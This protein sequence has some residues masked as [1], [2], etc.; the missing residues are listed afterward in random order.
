MMIYTPQAHDDALAGI[1][2]SAHPGDIGLDAD[3]AASILNR[4]KYDPDTAVSWLKS[5]KYSLMVIACSE[6]II[7][8]IMVQKYNHGEFAPR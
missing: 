8:A 1:L 5:D 4:K 7:L 2:G 3:T 6:Q